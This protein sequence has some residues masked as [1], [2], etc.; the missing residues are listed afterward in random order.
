MKDEQEREIAR[1]IEA[2]L[3]EKGE[4]FI[5]NDDH[6]EISMEVLREMGKFINNF[7]N[8]ICIFY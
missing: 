5:S 4:E 1:R 8:S 2:R 7:V 6:C 3:K